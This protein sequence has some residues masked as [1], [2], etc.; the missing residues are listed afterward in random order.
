VKKL[1]NELL[2]DYNNSSANLS[3]QILRGR[4]LPIYI[5]PNGGVVK[6]SLALLHFNYTRI[7]KAHPKF[8]VPTNVHL[9]ESWDPG[10]CI[11]YPPETKGVHAD[12][13]YMCSS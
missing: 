1:P 8:S 10:T 2:E 9:W 13:R 5:S 3:F 12:N 7:E 4:A 6:L 11:L